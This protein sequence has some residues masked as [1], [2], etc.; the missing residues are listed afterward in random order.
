ML[1]STVTKQCFN[2]LLDLFFLEVFLHWH[3]TQSLCQQQV[4]WWFR[5]LTLPWQISYRPACSVSINQVVDE[6]RISKIS[7]AGGCWGERRLV[8]G[9]AGWWKDQTP[10]TKVE[11]RE[12]REAQTDLASQLVSPWR[13]ASPMI[14][15]APAERAAENTS[16]PGRVQAQGWSSRHLSIWP[17]QFIPSFQPSVLF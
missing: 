6:W 17:L 15:S 2:A 16:R 3:A 5:W 9:N 14:C 7:D 12:E 10:E 1:L 8:H 13:T 11:L 4:L